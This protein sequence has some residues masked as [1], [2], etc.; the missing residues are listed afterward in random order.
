M[1]SR[2]LVLPQLLAQRASEHPDRLLLQD[3]AGRQLTYGETHE[4]ALTWADTLRRLDVKPGEALVTMLPTGIESCLVWLGCSWLGA[5]EAP[6]NTM[7]RDRMLQYLLENTA[8]RVGVFAERFL[9]LLAELAPDLGN[10]EVVVVPDLTAPAP[11][12]GVRI[13]SS[14][15][16]LAQSSPARD[17]EGPAH[18]DIA[19]IIHTS[20]TT[21]PSKGVLVPWAELY[22]FATTLPDEAID[23][24]EA[25]YCCL[26]T[27]HVGG[28]AALYTVVLSG[29]RLVLREVFSVREF[30]ADVRRFRCTTTGLIGV[31]AQLLAATP[32]Q[33]DDTDHPLRHLHVAPLFSGIDAFERRFGV[34]SHTGYGMT[35]IGVPLAMLSE[36]RSDWRSCGR[37]RPGYEVRIVDEHDEELPDGEV[38]ELLVRSD[39]PWM[40]NAGYFNMPEATARAWRN[41]WFHTGD[42]FRRDADG[43]YYFV[44]RLKD[45]MRRK[46]E[47]ISSLEVEAHVRTH[48]SVLEVAAIAAPSEFGPGEDE[49][50]VLVV[51]RPGAA[52]EPSAL[53]DFLEPSMPRFM[54]PR[55]VEIVEDL[56]KTQTARV[57]KVELRAKAFTERTWDHVTGRYLGPDADRR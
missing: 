30:W 10:L 15:D 2:D 33:V 22:Q 13:I 56:P 39:R 29:A 17:L 26:P 25:H 19:N 8:A 36:E 55:Y 48:P 50:K 57:R 53:L 41:G 51:L 12:I 1:Y 7:Y 45:A 35:E 27:F 28:K 18:Y 42:G 14:D 37:V 21:G 23:E 20:G 9:P 54:L 44:D 40:L 34:K 31:M 24:H 32:A 16:L 46:G 38:G 6:I 3:V 43:N 4:A 52:L 47:N 49:V 5:I 11:D